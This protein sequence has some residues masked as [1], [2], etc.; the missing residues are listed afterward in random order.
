MIKIVKKNW[1]NA[2][3]LTNGIGVQHVNKLTFFNK[4]TNISKLTN[5]NKLTNVNKL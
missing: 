3:K 4:L 5:F 1:T 2:N